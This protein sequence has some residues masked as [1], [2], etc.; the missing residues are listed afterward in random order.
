M[1]LPGQRDYLPYAGSVPGLESLPY[2]YVSRMDLASD[3]WTIRVVQ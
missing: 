2:V 1:I 3:F